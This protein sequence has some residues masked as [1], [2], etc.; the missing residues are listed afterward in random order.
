MTPK[1]AG[2]L[3]GQLTSSM[4][5]KVKLEERY[6]EVKEGRRWKRGGG[7]GGR[8]DLGRKE[9]GRREE[10]GRRCKAWKIP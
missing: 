7:G 1:V 5:E 2:P 4:K 3:A 8:A 10:G 6:G 9:G